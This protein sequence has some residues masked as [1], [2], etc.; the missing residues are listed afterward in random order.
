MKHERAFFPFNQKAAAV[1]KRAP[2]SQAL[3]HHSPYSSVSPVSLSL[4]LSFHF[5]CS[6]SALLPSEAALQC[7]LFSFQFVWQPFLPFTLFS[8]FPVCLYLD[9]DPPSVFFSKDRKKICGADKTKTN[10][11][12]HIRHT[13]WCKSSCKVECFE[14]KTRL[15]LRPKQS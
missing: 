9:V 13:H 2:H 7:I 4:S 5:L 14:W 3:F 11:H 8:L 15:F 1:L 10:T 12:T 6:S